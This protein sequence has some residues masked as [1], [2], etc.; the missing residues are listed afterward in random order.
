MPSSTTPVES[1]HGLPLGYGTP[2]NI[3]LFI[4]CQKSRMGYGTFDFWF[5]WHFIPY[6]IEL[7]QM[8]WEKLSKVTKKGLFTF[9]IRHYR[10]QPKLN[11][12]HS[13]TVGRKHKSRYSLGS[14][15]WDIFSD[16]IKFSYW[17]MKGYF[18]KATF[19]Q[20][21]DF[22]SSNHFTAHYKSPF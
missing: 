9:Y 15:H 6:K 14:R 4:V 1:S 13:L 10:K 12:Y 22:F 16:A 2:M 5:S 8:F 11:G 18:L 3:I 19:Y 20:K 17:H 21:I 7:L